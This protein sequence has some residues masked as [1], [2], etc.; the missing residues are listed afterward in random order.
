MLISLA[1]AAA[2]VEPAFDPLR[3]FTGQTRGTARL[4]VILR[5]AK[6]VTVRG[7]GKMRADGTLVLDQMVTDGGG[8][9]R[10]RRWLLRETTSGHY[11]GT[12]SDARGPVIGEVSGTTLRLSFTSD[13]GF[14]IRQTL[15]LQP[16]G[17]TLANRLEAR[18]FGIRVAVLTERI[19]KVD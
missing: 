19:V 8:P 13:G 4:K 16:D 18:R 14:R 6:P 9:P 12:L 2:P 5:K 11:A 3:F 17:R 1:L 7:T 15:T 10:A